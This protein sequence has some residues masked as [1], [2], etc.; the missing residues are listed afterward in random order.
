M[1]MM[2][3]IHFILVVLGARVFSLPLGTGC[4]KTV[5]DIVFAI[6]SSF[7]LYPEDFQSQLVLI[8]SLIDS[9]SIGLNNIQVGV[10]S[11]GTQVEENIKLN[12]F[13]SKHLLKIAVG[14]IVQLN[15]GTMTHRAIHH[16]HTTM[17]R[18]ENGGRPWAK[19][20][21]ILI[22]DG[23]SENETATLIEASEA[24]SKKIEIFSIGVGQAVNVFEIRAVASEPKESHV[25]KVDNFKALLS[26]DQTL[27]NAA[28]HDNHAGQIYETET[29]CLHKTAD[30]VFLV[31]SSSS[32]WNRDFLTYEKFVENVMLSYDIA[33]NLTR[34]GVIAFSDAPLIIVEMNDIQSKENIKTFWKI[35]HISG[36]TNTEKAIEYAWTKMLEEGRD[37]RPDAAQVLILLT[38]GH[39][40]DNDKAVKKAQFLKSKGVDIFVIAVGIQS[41]I[42]DL[43][44]IASSEDHYFNVEKSKDL[45]SLNK[46][47]VKGTCHVMPSQNQQENMAHC[48]EVSTDAVFIYDRNIVDGSHHDFIINII[49]SVVKSSGLNSDALRFGVI[50]DAPHDGKISS[51]IDLTNQWTDSDFKKE[52]NLDSKKADIDLLFQKVRIRY[53]QPLSHNAEKK[54]VILFLDSNLANKMAATIEAKRLKRSDVRII[55]VKI[56]KHAD[57]KQIGQLASL[58][59]DENVIEAPFIHNQH[60]LHHVSDKL[61]KILCD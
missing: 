32:I 36:S 44:K 29:E 39:S 40:D 17:F 16:I 7:S 12:D 33:P 24:R 21:I 4:S 2:L 5:S 38:D 37:S 18:P 10:V 6:D 47:L 15:Q 51:D 46:Q 27:S 58:P 53:F 48:P 43:I 56:G 28:C 14:R 49:T 13:D 41:N 9:F 50:R 23:R 30:V 35:P 52:L 11:Y 26:I 54:I 34:V 25:F 60:A 59:T 8:N 31:D 42:K 1:A 45:L 3:S 57:V 20:Q 55:V 19:K 22:T 61:I